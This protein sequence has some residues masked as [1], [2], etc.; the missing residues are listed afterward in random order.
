[1]IITNL[2]SA[3][4]INHQLSLFRQSFNA[5]CKTLD[6]PPPVCL[7]IQ[8]LS[9][10]RKCHW[11]AIILSKGGGRPKVISNLA[12]AVTFPHPVFDRFNQLWISW[13][14]FH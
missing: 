4:K 9:P 1:M 5:I 8:E 10:D 11:I 2:S 14:F 12:G 6:G 7:A 3:G 13:S